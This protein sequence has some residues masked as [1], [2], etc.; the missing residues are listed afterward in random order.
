[1]ADTT[2]LIADLEAEGAD[3]DAVV[4][5]LAPTE[6]LR[7]T[8]AVGWTI[9]DQIGHLAWT[10]DV[11]RDA[12]GTAT[13]DEAAAA[14]FAERMATAAQRGMAIVDIGAHEWAGLEVDVLLDR[15][16]AGRAALAA[17]LG[18]VPSGV[19]IPWFGP[20]MS[21]ASMVT[22][23]LMETWAHGCDVVDTLG[24]ERAATDR[25]RAVAHLGVRTR[26]FAFRVRELEPPAEEFRVEITGPNGDVWTWGPADA[27]QRV[28]ADALA[29]CRLVTQRGDASE[30]HADGADARTWLTIAQAFAGPPGPGRTSAE[31]P[32]RTSAD[33]PATAD[34]AGGA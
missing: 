33:Q 14:R 15:W 27:A 29:F 7:D 16:R 18:N 34:T 3:L 32:G 2:L 28:T 17:A 13:G 5:S 24:I 10:D 25:L 22:A 8:P 12:V 9:A 31:Q 1:M 21:A 6:W 20:P 23:R 4:A 30:V 19:K 26:D 11:A